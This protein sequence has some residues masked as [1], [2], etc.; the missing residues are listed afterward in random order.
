MIREALISE[1]VRGRKTL[2]VGSL[3]QT[4]RYRL[5][6]VLDGHA[7]SLTG[8]DLDDETIGAFGGT[9]CAAPDPRIARGNMETHDFGERFE[10]I[11]AGDV[12]EHFSNPGLF[13]DNCRHHL[14][15]DGVLIL[16]TP[17]AKWPT[18]FLRPNPTH[19]LWH[20]RFTLAHLL[21]RHGFAVEH[22]RY[23]PGNKS[24]YPLP[25]RLLAWRQAMLMVAAPKRSGGAASGGRA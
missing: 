18:V 20:D 10:V 16:T 14:T 19:T 9:P 5:W 15:G 1:R 13:L 21:D 2:D 12:I 6:D 11:V 24:S 25:L 8:I 23:Y 22:F 3:G 4:D 17:N 7:G